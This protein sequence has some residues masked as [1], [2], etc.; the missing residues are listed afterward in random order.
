M[1]HCILITGYHDL[2]CR[3]PEDFLSLVFQ[4]NLSCKGPTVALKYFLDERQNLVS[5]SHFDF[6]AAAF[7]P[8]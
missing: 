2:Y 3:V 7:V 5:L 4:S 8:H 1:S 6:V